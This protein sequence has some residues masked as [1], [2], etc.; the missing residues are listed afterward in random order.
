MGEVEAGIQ[1]A[2]GGGDDSVAGRV[3]FAPGISDGR[4]LVLVQAMHGGGLAKPGQRVSGALVW[5]GAWVARSSTSPLGN[6]AAL[7]TEPF[8]S[9][10]KL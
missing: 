7:G 4:Q 8:A 1:G 10:S 5:R 3:E 6:T 9:G 2:A